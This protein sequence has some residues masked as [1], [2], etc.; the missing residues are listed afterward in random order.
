[1]VRYYYSGRDFVIEDFQRAKPFSSFLP[2]IAGKK[3]KPIW[4]FYCSRGQAFAGF[5][6]D[7]KETPITPFDSANSAYQNIA[8]KGFRT[9][10][11]FQ[12]R[13]IAPFFD[14]GR[15]SRKMIVRRTCLEIEEENDWFVL[16]VTYSTVPEESYAGLIRKVELTP[17]KTG[18]YEIVDGLP[19]IFPYGLSNYCYKELVSL[20]AGYCQVFGKEKRLP[21]IKFKT[22]TKDCAEVSEIASGNGYVT[23]DAFGNRFYPIVDPYTVFGEDTSLIRPEGFSGKTY[24]ELLDLEEQTENKLPSAFSMNRIRLKS[25]ETYPFFS[26]FGS[27]DD[28][29][30]FEEKLASLTLSDVERMISRSEE[31][32]DELIR[33]MNIRTSDPVFDEYF[34]QSYLDN[35]L[36]GGFPTRL[37]ENQPYY[38]YSRKH[39]DMERDYNAFQIPSKYYSSGPGNFRDVNQNRRNDLY[40][41]PYLK[42][43][44]IHLFFD[45]IQIDGQNPLN[46]RPPVFRRKADF[47]DAIFAS[48]ESPRKEELIRLS[49]GFEPSEMFTL[50]KDGNEEIPVEERFEKVLSMCVQTSEADFGE[51]YWIDHWTYNVDLL[52]NYRSVYPDQM[53]EMLFKDDYRYFYSPVYVLPRDEKYCLLPDGKVRQYG[54]IDLDELKR[55]CERKAF[56]IRKTSWLKDGSGNEVRTSLM[57]KIVHLIAVKFSTLDSQ[58]L[59]IEMECEKPGWNDAMNGLPGLFASGESESIELLRLV[60][61]AKEQL[62]RFSGKKIVFLKEQ[63]AFFRALGDLSG[64]LE[65]HHLT[66]FA[67]WDR[68]TTLREEFRREVR[69][70]VSGDTKAIDAEEI[71]PV[72]SSFERILTDGVKRAKSIGNGLIPSYWIYRVVEYEQTGK[73]THL[74]YPSVRVKAFSQEILPPF[75]EAAAR[76]FKLPKAMLS[77]DLYENIKKSGIYDPELKIYKT[78]APIDSAPFEIGRIHA[79][80][81]G[82]L[83]RECDFLHMTY[84]YLLGLLKG[85]FIDE[86]YEESRTNLVCFMKPEVYGR[87]TLENSS[88]I[89]PG[90]N[91]DSKLHGR[92]FFARLTGANTELLEMGALL[93]FGDRLFLV[94]DGELKLNLKPRLKKEMFDERNEAAFRLFDSTD[95]VYVNEEKIDTYPSAKI[96]FYEVDGV[97]CDEIRGT[98]AENIRKGKVRRIRA[99]IGK[100]A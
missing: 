19:I 91:P 11:R 98:T 94:E 69:E 83:E 60:L 10:V 26:L 81:K 61:F 64:L 85:G 82:W 20:M 71:L 68:A 23:A 52:E 37:T 86:F 21:F 5:G 67:F 74:G 13:I 4:A 97:R 65:T 15:A 24:E 39:G 25:G 54:A 33:P 8:L 1:M 90:N 45:L 88:F 40:F 6:V 32:V 43:Y 63:E 75:L 66:R 44:N 55:E 53:E 47:D 22:S 93:F 36:R 42:D 12:N 48:F 56:D 89:V 38:L 28:R 14:E 27:F 78:C 41:A 87:S 17:K 3:G 49:Y 59:G 35:C 96:L 31:I 92:G 80:T 57:A 46:V 34:R 2:A 77:R 7:S 18:E 76:S 50:L 73:T 84:K 51:G 9:F 30:A 16:R 72:L 58:Q 70:C 79:F 95:I 62:E 100:G 99:Y 29:N